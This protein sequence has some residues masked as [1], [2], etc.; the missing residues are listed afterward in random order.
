MSVLCDSPFYHEVSI[1]L[2]GETLLL[3]IDDYSRFLFVEPVSSTAA[4]AVIPKLDQ[5]FATFGTPCVVKSDN[6]VYHSVEKNL[7][8]WLM[9]LALNIARSLCS[10]QGPLERWRDLLKR[11][12][13]ASGLQNW[14][15]EVEAIL[16]Y[17]CTTPHETTGV[18]PAVLLLKRPVRNKLPQANHINP[19]FKIICKH[20]SL[21]KS[22]I[23]L[24]TDNK[25]YWY[26]EQC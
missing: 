14:S 1:D 26:V 6:M 8:R 4:S 25:T 5:P 3:M 23:K 7:L 20:D 21:Q 17:C 9:C 10:G 11:E 22:K 18:A 16:H 2:D 12:R 13:N 19:V 24:H 15:K